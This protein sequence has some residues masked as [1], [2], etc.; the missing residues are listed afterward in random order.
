MGTFGRPRRLVRPSASPLPTS[1]TGGSREGRRG[2]GEAS[3]RP[4]PTGE[5]GVENGGGSDAQ[6]ARGGS[7]E[8]GLCSGT[9]SAFCCSVSSYGTETSFGPREKA[10]R[11]CLDRSW[12]AHHSASTSF[13]ISFYFFQII[14]FCPS[15][16]EQG[17]EGSTPGCA[18]VVVLAPHVLPLF[19]LDDMIRHPLGH[20]G[21]SM[22]A[23]D[24]DIDKC[25]LLRCVATRHHRLRIVKSL[26][27]KCL[28]RHPHPPSP[29]VLSP[30]ALP[31][32]HDDTQPR[33]AMVERQGQQGGPHAGAAWSS[34]QIGGRRGGRSNEDAAVHTVGGECGH[35]LSPRKARA[36]PSPNGCRAKPAFTSSSQ[37]RDCL[38][39]RLGEPRI[40]CEH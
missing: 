29:P 36:A 30:P 20:V 21:S 2:A 35:P 6:S 39:G 22:R 15:I 5:S 12:S 16:P 10:K 25:H 28:P 4:A 26:S 34:N 9:W 37:P 13:Y 38:L 8:P 1:G 18:G 32:P 14:F 17:G 23:N 31:S 11:K 7:N 27:A 3:A 24:S 40:R 33:E 19:R